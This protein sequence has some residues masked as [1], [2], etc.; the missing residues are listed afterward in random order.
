MSDKAENKAH[1]FINKE[2]LKMERNSF[3]V[4]IIA[5]TVSYAA[6]TYWLNAIRADAALWLLWT[7]IIIQFALY[8]SIFIAS[9]R[10]AIISGLNQSAALVVFIA[11]AI[12]GR[13]NDWELLIIP[14]TVIVM[15]IISAR[16][17]NVSETSKHLLP[18]E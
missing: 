8:F 1:E 12:A 6:I 9:Y 17:K 11:L 10:R 3:A 13:I 5:I 2:V 7:L 4:R 14:L 15:L 18:K 16:V